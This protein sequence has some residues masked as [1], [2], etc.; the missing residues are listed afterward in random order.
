[1]DTRWIWTN[2]FLSIAHSQETLFD[3]YFQ[4]NRS[5]KLCIIKI[6]NAYKEIL[7]EKKKLDILFSYA[8]IDVSILLYIAHS[9]LLFF[10][11]STC[12]L[13][14][15]ES[16]GIRSLIF[17]EVTRWLSTITWTTTSLCKLWVVFPEFFFFWTSDIIYCTLYTARCEFSQHKYKNYFPT[18]HRTVF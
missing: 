4:E 12:G 16:S 11:V 18:N 10:S 2:F 3:I 17:L 7:E 15:S 6:I 8:T 5:Q 9:E 1:M 13:N 14:I